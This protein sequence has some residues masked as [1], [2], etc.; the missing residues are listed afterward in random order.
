MNEYESEPVPGLPENLPD[1]EYIIWQGQPE[2]G[3]LARRVFHVRGVCAYFAI[4]L[5][6]YVWST[7]SGTAAGG[8]LLATIAWPLALGTV[9]L[10][11]LLLL[12]WAFARATLYTITNR[13]IVLRFGV[14][15]P[16]M[17]NLPLSR[18]ESAD[19]AEYGDHGDIALTV[20]PGERISYI[21]L[22]PHARPWHVSKVKPSLRG[23]PN[24]RLAARLLADAVA[25]T[26][27]TVT[28]TP[29]PSRAASR[30][31]GQVVGTRPLAT[32]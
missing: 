10:A 13:R 31:A 5:A 16:M 29:R 12:A 30:P 14:A 2:W 21:A 26:G 11:M 15:L 17:I 25:H 4:L 20:A 7:R 22:W 24:A 23:L 18:I 1:G 6:W 8:D 19:L 3:A 27:D 9:S 28:V 32:S